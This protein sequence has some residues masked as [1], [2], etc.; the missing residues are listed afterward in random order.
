M[1]LVKCMLTAVLGV[2][3]AVS[4][5]QAFAQD[6][7]CDSGSARMTRGNRVGFI[8]RIR[9]NRSSYTSNCCQTAAPCCETA[10]ATPCCPPAPCCQ[11]PAPCCQTACCSTPSCGGCNSCSSCGHASNGCCRQGLVRNFRAQ[12]SCDCCAYTSHTSGCCGTATTGCGGCAGC[13]NGQIMQ[14]SSE[15]VVVPEASGQPV[16]PAPAPEAPKSTSSDT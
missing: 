12:R 4:S 9:A 8:A 5:S 6:C 3:V 10:A 14:G 11:T 2:V 1:S 7:C 13:A 16:A 15:G